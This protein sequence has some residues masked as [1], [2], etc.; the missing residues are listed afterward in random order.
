MDYDAQVAYF[1]RYNSVNFKPDTLGDMVFNGVASNVFRGAFV[2]GVQG[3][4]AYRLNE[5]HTLRAG[6]ISSGELTNVNNTDAV[7]PVDPGTGDVGTNPQTIIDPVSKV[8]WIAGFYL[9]DEWKLTNQLT[10]N[11][12]FRFDQM[13]QFVNTNQLS[14]RVNMTYTPWDG[15]KI[16]A[17]YAR[18]FTPP[19]QALASPTNTLLFLNTTLQPEVLQ[20][21]P[22]LPE[23]SHVFDVG[24]TQDFGGFLSGL[25]IGVDGYYKIAKDLIDDGQFG[26]AYVLTAFNYEKGENYGVEWTAKYKN[27]PFSLYGNLAWAVQRATNIVSNQ[28]L[29]GA[30]ELAFIAN[31]WVFTDHAQTYTASGGM[32]YVWNGTRIS[33]DMIYGSGLRAGDFNLDHV[34]AYGQM[35]LGLSREIPMPGEKPVT[36]RFDVLNVFDSTYEI[37]NGSGIGVFAPQF[38]PR[39]GYFVGL[40]QKL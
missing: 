20:S 5:A 31:S 8:G 37:R 3:D 40:S 22:V 11:Y 38:G 12:G 21:S 7:L 2:N 16:H 35:N 39:R 30:D 14:P 6:F 9:Q 25:Q 32:A 27:G 15:T 33:A 34:P 18:Y 19:P 26:A 36:V 24:A 1:T 4:A 23:R 13:W 29:F 17:G 10:L 28:F